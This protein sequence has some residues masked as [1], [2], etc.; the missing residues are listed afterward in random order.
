MIYAFDYETTG[1]DPLVNEVFGFVLTDEDGVSEVYD[2]DTDP[3]ALQVLKDFWADTSIEKIAHNLKFEL[4]FTI[5]QLGITIPEGTILHDTMI[6]SQIVD[7]LERSH[8]LDD[9]TNLYCGD[10]E[11]IEEWKRVDGLVKKEAELRGNYQLVNRH[12]MH[13]YQRHDGFRTMLL[14]KMFFTLIQ[15]YWENYRSEIDVVVATQRMEAFG[16]YP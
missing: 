6:M 10:R 5:S 2:L 12:L 13:T 11:L 8:S 9:L 4:H 7:N 3:K 1:F 15:P 14:Y 16:L